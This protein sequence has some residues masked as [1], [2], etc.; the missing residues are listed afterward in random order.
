[1]IR[2]GVLA[3]P[4]A[5]G[6]QTYAIM[7]I[8]VSPTRLAEVAAELAKLPEI[9][10]VGIC[11]GGFDISAVAL[12]RSNE[13][14]YE[15]IADRLGQIPGIERTSTAHVIRLVKREFSHPLTPHD[16]RRP[17]DGLQVPRA[18]RK[19]ARNGGPVARPRPSRKGTP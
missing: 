2:I 11:T 4:L 13:H 6:Y 15:L 10:F 17:G 19:L 8:D 1:M 9:T 5:L 18:A 16:Q 12:I 3:D 14:M 7:A